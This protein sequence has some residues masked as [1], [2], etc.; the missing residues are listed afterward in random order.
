MTDT[1]EDGYLVDE[2]GTE[3]GYCNA[4]GEE[5]RAGDDCCEDGEVVPH[6]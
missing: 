3:W 5:A 6:D 2:Y 1:N 4:C